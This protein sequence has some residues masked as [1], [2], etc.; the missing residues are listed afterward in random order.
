MFSLVFDPIVQ[1]MGLP[2]S[3]GQESS[4]NIKT[5]SEVLTL[6]SNAKNVFLFLSVFSFPIWNDKNEEE[7]SPTGT[8]TAI[9]IL[10]RLSKARYRQGLFF[11]VRREPGN[12]WHVGTR[13]NPF[14]LCPPGNDRWC[15]TDRAEPDSVGDN[16][17]T[18]QIQ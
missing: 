12:F 2:L 8:Q 4:Y 15:R 17:V 7:I 9:N 1:E 10:Q 14:L 11:F 18:A 3:L 6:Y 13:L 5:L 16:T